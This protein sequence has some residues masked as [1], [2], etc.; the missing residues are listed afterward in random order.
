MGIG[1]NG[2]I[3]EFVHPTFLYESIWCLI[4]FLILHF[5]YKKKK[6]NGE[7]FFAYIAFYGFGRMFIEG[8]RTDSLYV[9]IFRISQVVGLLSVVVGV[10][11]IVI[12]RLIATKEKDKSE[13]NEVKTDV[14]DN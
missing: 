6:F 1:T 14:A 5:I 10:I 12:M 13:D 3:F 11:A 8:L 4:G 2:T 9:G 7:I